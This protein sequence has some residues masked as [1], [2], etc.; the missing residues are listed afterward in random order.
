MLLKLIDGDYAL[1]HWERVNGVKSFYAY[2][3]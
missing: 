2:L 1:Y 3:F